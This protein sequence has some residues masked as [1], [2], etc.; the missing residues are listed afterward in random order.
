[1]RTFKITEKAAQKLFDKGN[2]A[3]KSILKDELGHEFFDMKIIDKVKSYEDA[4]E[5]ASEKLRNECCIH[6]T[7]TPDV[8]AYKKLK[9]IIAVI[10]EEWI[11]DWNNGDQR[12]W[13]PWFNMASGSG[14]GFSHSDYCYA[15]TGTTVG[16]RLC[17]ATKEKCDY[18]AN[19]FLR[20]YEELLTTK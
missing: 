15:V 4:L 9:L 19:T 1:M 14:F 7:D 12:K 18:V 3:I 11:A 13:W 8:V 2:D 6:S 17:Y 5:L 16:S 20:L 10:N